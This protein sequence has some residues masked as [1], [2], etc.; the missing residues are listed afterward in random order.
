MGSS[1]YTLGSG[2]KEHLGKI[3][4]TLA[5][6]VLSSLGTPLPLQTNPTGTPTP[7]TDQETI[8]HVLQKYPLPK[9]YAAAW[10]PLRRSTETTLER[11]PRECSPKQTCRTIRQR[12]QIILHPA[13][14]LASINGPSDTLQCCPLPSWATDSAPGQGRQQSSGIISGSA[15]TFLGSFHIWTHPSLR[16]K[17]E[18]SSFNVPRMPALITNPQNQTGKATCQKI[19][20]AQQTSP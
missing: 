15:M 9:A 19:F 4:F 13:P 7:G 17:T 8:H 1:V 5:P 10:P 6:L 12:A 20:Y 16:E 2:H 11:K 18:H 14:A 3:H